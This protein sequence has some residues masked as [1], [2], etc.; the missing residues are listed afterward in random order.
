MSTVSEYVE[1]MEAA[2]DLAEGID[3]FIDPD[4][5]AAMR[6][7]RT[8]RGAA[9]FGAPV[10]SIIRADGSI[11]TPDGR[12]ER[13]SAPKNPNAKKPD[14]KK[15]DTAKKPAASSGTD[16]P[17]RG[18]AQSSLK[19]GRKKTIDGWEV[20]PVR[21]G[22]GKEFGITNDGNGWYSY[23][24]ADEQDTDG[25]Y[26]DSPQKAR[27]ALENWHAKKNSSVKKKA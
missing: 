16:A 25:E 9:R 17:R 11:V 27:E 15:P 20:Y 4:T 8:P 22:D 3:T 21:A 10:G 14:S 5:K 13:G 12:E 23:F 24:G 7:V 1:K 18:N 19:M 6:R 2:L 26:Y